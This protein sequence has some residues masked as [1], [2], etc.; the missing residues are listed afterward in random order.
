MLVAMGGDPSE[1]PTVARASSHGFPLN[2]WP[3]PAPI[4]DEASDAREQYGYDASWTVM[5]AILAEAGEDG[6]LR[7]FRA[8]DEHTT[9]YV[10]DGPPE[11]TALPNDW[12]RFLDLAEELGGA[13]GATALVVAWAATSDAQASLTARD[14]AR[15]A[16]R[17]LLE[18]GDGWAAP[19]V[20]RLAMDGWTFDDGG[21]RDRPRGGRAGPARRADRRRRR[22]GPV[23]RRRPGGGVRGC[24]LRTGARCRARAGGGTRPPRSTR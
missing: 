14:A 21:R 24:H 23:A 4:K 11:R 8:A 17:E 18:D 22:R 20:V 10:G 13:D 19:A 5:R 9:A 16:Y 6:L 3:P 1:P 2:D 12:R 15:K 7:V